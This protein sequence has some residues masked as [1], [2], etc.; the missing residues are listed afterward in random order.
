MGVVYEGWDADLQRKVAIKVLRDSGGS[1]RV[2]LLREARAMAK[3]SHPN[4]ATVFEVATHEGRDF[5][6][7]EMVDGTHLAE[8]LRAGRSREEILRAFV[9]AGRGLAAA[10]AAGMI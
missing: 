5:I 6:A 3:L 10:H 4:V 8:W 1:A 2:R 7:I 9:A